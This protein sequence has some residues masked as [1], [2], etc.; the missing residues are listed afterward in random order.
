MAV[1]KLSK[2]TLLD[3]LRVIEEVRNAAYAT[4]CHYRNCRKPLKGMVR[5]SKHGGLYCSEDCEIMANLEKYEDL[6]L[7][8]TDVYINLN[9]Q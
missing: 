8:G 9:L 6:S 7:F 1:K 3:N 2:I 5:L 4:V